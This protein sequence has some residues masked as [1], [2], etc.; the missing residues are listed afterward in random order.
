VRQRF[1]LASLTPA[2][3][4]EGVLRRARDD[5]FV[6]TREAEEALKKAAKSGTTDAITT[7]WHTVKAAQAQRITEFYDVLDDAEGLNHVIA[8]DVTGGLRAAQAEKRDPLAALDAMIGLDA[9]KREVRQI[10]A[11]VKLAAKQKEAGLSAQRPRLNLLFGGNPGTGKTTVAELLADALA[12]VGYLKNSKVVRARVQDLTADPEQAVKK[13]FEDN[14]GAVIFI[15]EMHQ[16]KDTQE[17]KRALRAMIPYL[18]HKDYADTVVIG[19]GYTSELKDL[20]RDVD[21]GAERRFTTVPFADYDDKEIAK[22]LD[23]MIGDRERTLAP[24]AKDA[25]MQRLGRM[26]RQ[27]KHFGNA[28]SVEVLLDTAEKKR[29]LRLADAIDQRDVSKDELMALE[30]E[31]FQEPRRYTKEEVLAEL[32]Q[33]VGLEGVKEKLEEIAALTEFARSVG[34]DPLEFFE[35]YFIFEGPPGTGKTTVARLVG[36][37]FQACDLMPSADLIETNGAKLQGRYVGQTAGDVQ[38]LFEQAWGGVLFIDEVSGLSRSGGSFKD[39]AAKE[40][41]KQMEDHRGRFVLVVA[42]YAENIGEFLALDPGLERRFGNRVEFTAMSAAQAS[43]ALKKRII[44]EGLT[45]APAAKA[46][47]LAQMTELRSLRGFASGGDVRRL[48]NNVV[49][50][51]AL[52]F[53]REKARG[54]TIDPRAITEDAVTRAFAELIAERKKTIAA[55]PADPSVAYD[56]KAA[57]AGT[58]AVE[59]PLPSPSAAEQKLLAAVA[60]VDQEFGGKLNDPK[61]YAK[62]TTSPKSVYMQRLAEKLDCKPEEAL[63]QLTEVR[64]VMKKL[65]TVEKLV[66]RFQYHCP[67]CGGI[68]SATCGYRDYPLAWKMQHSLKKPWTEKVSSKIEVPSPTQN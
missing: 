4:S 67:Y 3:V 55:R 20:L 22:I 19:A 45:L 36:K 47:V 32:S 26:R 15:D 28:G 9:V 16:L 48:M 21:P 58:K 11:Q 43:E 12:S 59:E 18:G 68:D 39:E 65:V 49:R 50:Q 7:L 64:E 57:T 61:E 5:G 60:E 24:E 42:D 31:D 10:L 41:L 30:P 14:K 27:M 29:T 44:G 53:A 66:Q 33:L 38:K 13:L 2:Q 54:N 23:K 1:A 62:Q 46:T 40:M 37:F 17:G 8:H 63:K 6:F 34:K 56:A 51:Q 35:P 25:A 52:L